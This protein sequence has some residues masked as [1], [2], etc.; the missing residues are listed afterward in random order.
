MANKLETANLNRVRAE[1]KLRPAPAH[2]SDE[3]FSSAHDRSAQVAPVGE[4]E[5]EGERKEERGENDKR[6]GGRE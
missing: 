3:E 1:Q 2:D 6:V 4:I 5:R